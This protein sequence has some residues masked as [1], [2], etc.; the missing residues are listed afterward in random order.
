MGAKYGRFTIGVALAGAG[1]FCLNYTKGMDMEHHAQWAAAHGYPVPSYEIFL[2]GA[3][4]E[5]VGALLVGATLGAKP[6]SK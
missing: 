6:K 3:G 5:L 2:A 1:F 4:L